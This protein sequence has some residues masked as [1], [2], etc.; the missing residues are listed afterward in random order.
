MT[1]SKQPPVTVITEQQLA[2][3]TETVDFNYQDPES[4]ITYKVLSEF[5]WSSEDL[6]DY[7]SPAGYPVPVKAKS[8]TQTQLDIF[9]DKSQISPVDLTPELVMA[10]QQESWDLFIRRYN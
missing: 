8:W 10:I 6:V 5:I 1:V 4:E 9:K 2:K 7:P 3:M